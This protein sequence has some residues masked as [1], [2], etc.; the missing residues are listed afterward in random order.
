MAAAKL[1]FEAH[2]VIL[3]PMVTEKGVEASNDTNSYT[4]EVNPQATKEDV[5]QAVEALFDVKVVGV[6]TQNRKGKPR[7]SRFRSGRTSDWK[8][9]IVKLHADNRIDFF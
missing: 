9:A 1:R 7:R 2:Q 5:R 6:R 3:R 4:F 8:K